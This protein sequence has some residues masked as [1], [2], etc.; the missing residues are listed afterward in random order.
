[1]PGEERHALPPLPK[2]RRALPSVPG[3]ERHALPPLPV[4]NL[5]GLSNPDKAP[6]RKPMPTPPAVRKVLTN[7]PT[8]PIA[9]ERLDSDPPPRLSLLELDWIDDEDPSV[10]LVGAGHQVEAALSV[11]LIRHGVHVETAERS[12]VLDAVLAATPKLILVVGEA[13]RD[14]GAAVLRKLR[15]TEL[16]A[17]VPVA[18]LVEEE[19]LEARLQAFRNGASGVIARS[20]SVDAVAERVAALARA[21]DAEAAD[22]NFIG[23][24]TMR[25]LLDAFGKKIATTVIPDSDTE[26]SEYGRVRLLLGNGRH[27]VNIIDDFSVALR[28]TVL[29]AER[30]VYQLAGGT[31]AELLGAQA[32]AVARSAGNVSK[33]RVL[34]ADADSGRADSIARSL[35]DSG[36]QVVVTGFDPSDQLFERLRQFD[37]MVL[38]IGSEDVRDGGQHLIE[39]VQRDRRLSWASLLEASPTELAWAEGGGGAESLLGRLAALGDPERGLGARAESG[40]PFDTR[41]EVMGPAR[42]LRTLAPSSKPV[43]LKV[44]NP[45][46]AIQVDLSEG[47]IVGAKAQVHS[48]GPRTLEG[49]TA[50]AAFLA[51]RSGRVQV[52]RVEE[53]AVANIMNTVEGALN[54][55]ETEPPPVVPSEPPPPP[56]ASSSTGVRALLSYSMPLQTL[57]QRVLSWRERV[58]ISQTALIG[59]LSA[60]VVLAAVIAAVFVA[61]MPADTAQPD[62]ETAVPDRTRRKTRTPPAASLLERA[63]AG[64]REAIA[65]LEQRPIAARSVQDA[66]ALSKGRSALKRLEIEALRDEIAK[67]PALL[68]DK[69]TVRRL[70]SAGRD[71]AVA[72]EALTAIASLPGPSSADIIYQ[73]WIGTQERTAATHLAEELALT[74][75]IRKKASP[76]LAVALDLRK[77][78]SCEQN[79]A[80]LPRAL[81]EGDGRALRPLNRLIRRTGCGPNKRLDCYACLRKGKQLRE[82]IRAVRKRRGPRF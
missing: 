61:R 9:A 51:L 2:E 53:A 72:A 26:P 81:A 24:T 68:E 48:E 58:V 5:A 15:H 1:V 3:E 30:V 59:L 8:Q 19:N 20:P 14:G 25:D 70:I 62:A 11:A 50:L 47:L 77:A 57:V 13:A 67:N 38:L 31:T 46:L 56:A 65:A 33:I 27:V 69:A 7:A 28:N 73:I 32:Q 29:E 75:A 17:A 82:V 55:A 45:R 22:S 52:E 66:V 44:D 64:D 21:K 74:D 10:L 41:L 60:G 39:R 79:Q 40:A 6:P 80:L 63:S 35:R 78:E 42:M 76:A 34:L 23:E 18:V 54:M 37:P 16:G 71:P 12:A 43:R 4:P 49:S 36:A